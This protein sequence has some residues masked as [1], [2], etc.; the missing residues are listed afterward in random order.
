MLQPH[1]VPK[2][3]YFSIAA[4]LGV[5][6]VLTVVAAKIDL[7]MWNTPLAMGIALVKA[8]L[9]VLYFM[10]VRYQKPLA[11]LFAAGGF[12]WLMILFIFTFA[13]YITRH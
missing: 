2:S 6:L 10:H 4:I 3:I 9:I 8:M 5:L 12:A 1:I 7:G 13:D 11:R